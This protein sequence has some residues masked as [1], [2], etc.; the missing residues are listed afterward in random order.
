MGRRGGTDRGGGT[1]RAGR[2]GKGEGKGREISLLR[3]IL[4]VGAYDHIQLQMFTVGD[5]PDIEQLQKNWAG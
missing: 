3:S 4:K 1:E 5:E 2:G